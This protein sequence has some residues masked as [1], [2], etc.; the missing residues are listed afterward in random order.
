MHKKFNS[1]DDDNPIDKE[2]SFVNHFENDDLNSNVKKAPAKKKKKKKKRNL[3]STIIVI[4]IL[5][6]V[7]VILS[8]AVIV[9]SSDVLGLNGSDD[10]VTIDIPKG[11]TITQVAKILEEKNII[12]H[13]K[14]FVQ[15][16]KLNNKNMIVYPGRHELKDG[17]SYNDIIK[18]IKTQGKSEK[19]LVKI[20]FPEGITLQEAA[21]KLEEYEICNAEDF[22]IEFNRSYKDLDFDGLVPDSELKFYRM[23]GYFFPD[24]Y[25]FYKNSQPDSVCATIKTNF[26]RKVY[27][28]YYALIKEKGLTLDQVIIMASMVQQEAPTKEDMEKVASVF[29]NRLNNSNSYPLLQSDP[30]SKYVVETIKPNIN[31]VNE[32]EIFTAYD[33]YKGQGLPPGAIS[34]PGI[35]AIEAVLNPAKTDYLYFC[36]NLKT[37][38]FYYA[39]TLSQ[40]ESNLRIAGLK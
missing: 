26:S 37:K 6:A 27:T 25:E 7:S 15:F 34:N 35:E 36:S 11:T 28:K 14:L 29:W 18:N 20:M 19:D 4:T 38:K 32:E 3:A 16:C 21:E 5:L 24:T 40:H 31:E 13:P 33:T 17:M 8:T 12:S 30:T 2:D 1:M 39:K 23:E 9:F 22:I 10:I